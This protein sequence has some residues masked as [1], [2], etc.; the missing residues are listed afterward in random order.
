VFP[1]DWI[2][3][4]EM[5]GRDPYGLIIYEI[6][7]T[8][9]GATGTLSLVTPDGHDFKYMPRHDRAEQKVVDALFNVGNTATV[10]GIEIELIFT[11]ERDIVRVTPVS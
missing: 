2:A 7:A 8:K 11:G 5:V 10:Q 1:D 9:P 4:W 3:I 6:D